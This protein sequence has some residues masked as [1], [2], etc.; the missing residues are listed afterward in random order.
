MPSASSTAI[1]SSANPR[2]LYGTSGLSLS[3]VPRQSRVTVRYA[4]AKSA[5][6]GSHHPWLL[7]C[8]ASSTNGSPAPD[9]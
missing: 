5:R 8:P 7:D 6:T 1:T 2:V 4:A 3:P 9:T